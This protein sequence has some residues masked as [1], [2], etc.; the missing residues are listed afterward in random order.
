ME[1]TTSSGVS[2]SCTSG[3]GLQAKLVKS[4]ENDLI[5]GAN[6]QMRSREKN[7]SNLFDTDSME[8][9]EPVSTEAVAGLPPPSFSPS[10][11][12]HWLSP[13]PAFDSRSEE[14][15]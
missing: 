5:E 12:G 13:S 15:P 8:P 6:G 9:T 3:D 2:A 4:L 11:L 7:V 14:G 1:T 10:K